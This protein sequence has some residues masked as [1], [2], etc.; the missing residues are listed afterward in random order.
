MMDEL[1]ESFSRLRDDLVAKKLNSAVRIARVGTAFARVDSE[2]PAIT[3]NAADQHH[4]TTQGYY[5][6][7]LV[8]YETMY[9]ESVKGAPTE[10]YHGEVIISAEEAAKLQGVADE[11]A[12]GSAN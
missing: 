11:V 7:A 9:H 1:H 4:A 5:L 12:G 3:L 2:Y 6:A 8:I 10:F